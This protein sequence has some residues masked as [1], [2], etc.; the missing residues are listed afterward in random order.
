LIFQN[1]Y[2]IYFF[3]FKRLKQNC[4][5]DIHIK[6]LWCVFTHKQQLAC[7]V[8]EKTKSVIQ[9]CQNII[10]HKERKKI[11]LSQK[12]NVKA[13]EYCVFVIELQQGIQT[14]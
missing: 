6:S 3:V 10:I 13:S 12:Q 5:C 9:R 11:I 7:Q 14:K 2:F 4:Q 8:V 1:I